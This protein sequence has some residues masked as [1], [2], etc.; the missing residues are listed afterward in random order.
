MSEPI[1]DSLLDRI[2]KLNTLGILLSAEKD[3]DRLL[4]ML[5]SGAREITH[6]D[7]G[8]LYLLSGQE[9]RFEIVQT[10]SLG[11][12]MGGCSGRAVTFPA[13]PLYNEQG[14]PN[15]HTVAASAALENRIINIPDAYTATAYDFTGT[16]AFDARSGYRSRSF[17]SVP[18]SDHEGRLTGVLQLLNAIDPK[19]GEIVPFSAEDER[20][21]ASLASQAA[22]TLNRKRLIEELKTLLGSLTRLIANAIDEKSP[23]TGGHCRRVPVLT[24][25]LADAVNRSQMPPFAN[26]YLDEKKRYELEMAAW[27]H[28]CGKLITPEHIIDKHTKLETVWDRIQAIDA[29]LEILARDARIAF[30]E[31]KLAALE[32]GQPH[33]IPSLNV[34]FG[35]RLQT[36]AAD[37]EFL[38]RCNQ[39]RETM[40]EADLQRLQKLAS[41]H[42]R[43]AGCDVPILDA[44][45]LHCLSIRRGTLT[46][47]ERKIIESHVTSTI[48]MLEA[49]PFPEELKLV[50]LIAGGHHEKING[51]GYPLGLTVGQMPLQARI[52]AI[53]DIFEALTAADRPYRRPNTLAEALK[54]MERMRQDGHL[55]PDLF[56]LFIH[57]RIYL[58][59]AAAFLRP[60]QIDA[61]APLPALPSPP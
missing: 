11:I 38:R 51:T 46:D 15:L 47:E 36:L 61:G 43:M 17:L 33:D 10:A 1:A 59:Y 52:L 39:G 3:Y 18:M 57:E 56:D 53:A 24:M 32:E 27:L 40:A 20:L 48:H 21:V 7:G 50:P 14:L 44:D 4:E 41:I 25:L 16:R 37:R 45:E 8:T 49:L 2:E 28:D 55:D 13:I 34:E 26:F 60:E 6:A 58:D 23:Y 35:E 9:L 19:T 29:R 30:L 12:A 5:L 42:I 54:I 22:V 31:Q